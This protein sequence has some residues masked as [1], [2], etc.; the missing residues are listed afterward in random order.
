MKF[1]K[2]IFLLFLFIIVCFSL[3]HIETKENVSNNSY[4][5][6]ITA[7]ILFVLCFL[8]LALKIKVGGQYLSL[9]QDLANLQVEQKKLSSIVMALY[10]CFRINVALRDIKG[11]SSKIAVLNLSIRDELQQLLNDK[12]LESFNNKLFDI[13]KNPN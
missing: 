9:E 5:L 13:I 7:I 3:Y 4:F 11:S 12:E 2:V 10:K 8:L 6:A 1:F